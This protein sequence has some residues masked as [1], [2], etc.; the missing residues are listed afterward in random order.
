MGHEIITLQ[1]CPF[2]ATL[3]TSSFLL[4]LVALIPVV[5]AAFAGC[6]YGRSAATLTQHHPEEPEPHDTH[7]VREPR[8]NRAHLA[9]QAAATQTDPIIQQPLPAVPADV[10]TTE[11]IRS[12]SGTSYVVARELLQKYLVADLVKLCERAGLSPGRATKETMARALLAEVELSQHELERKIPIDRLT[13]HRGGLLNE[14]AP[15]ARMRTGNTR[16]ER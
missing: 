7:H 4:G 12:R 11:G 3:T 13:L 9:V 15:R 1:L 2:K 16:H 5:L 10:A 14:P 6:L 8:A